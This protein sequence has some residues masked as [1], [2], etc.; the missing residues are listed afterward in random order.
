MQSRRIFIIVLSIV[1]T[2]VASAQMVD[3]TGK[4]ID[5]FMVDEP[6][7]L[8][9]V[10]D[11]DAW[12]FGAVIGYPLCHPEYTEPADQY[13]VSVGLA[14]FALAELGNLTIHVMLRNMRPAEGSQ[15]REIPRGFLFNFVACP[16]Y[17]FEVLSWV[18]FSIMTHVAFDGRSAQVLATEF[19]ALLAHPD[20][21]SAALP[22][23]DGAVERK[24]FREM[25]DA[26]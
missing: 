2:S 15:K 5:A 18:G 16:N 12:A 13:S 14:I 21:A 17:T 20:A 4:R 9:G 24:S 6:P 11:D 1:C 8:D 10:L 26:D 23:L 3:S 19:V 22:E 7:V 25:L